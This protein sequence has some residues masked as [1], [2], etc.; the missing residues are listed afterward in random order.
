MK[1]YLGTEDS[2]LKLRELV[3]KYY[4]STNDVLVTE[5]IVVNETHRV[6]AQAYR[7]RCKRQTLSK[8]VI[9]DSTVL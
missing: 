6:L 9:Q 5:D 7:A 4:L 3:N 1:Q 8:Q 2:K